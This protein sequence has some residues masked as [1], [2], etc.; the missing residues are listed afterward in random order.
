MRACSFSVCAFSGENGLVDVDLACCAFS[1]SGVL[2][3]AAYHS[4]PSALSGAI[5]HCGNNSTG[6]FAPTDES[7]IV[8]AYPALL[9]PDCCVLFFTLA[10]TRNK[11]DECAALTVTVH[12]KDQKKDKVSSCRVLMHYT[13]T[14]HY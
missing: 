5:R 12:S 6:S 10:G 14:R 8:H 2:M 7:E 13:V 9:P 11:L 3:D 1:D 4:N